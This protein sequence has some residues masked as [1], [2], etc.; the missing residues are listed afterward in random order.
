[1][2]AVIIVPAEDNSQKQAYGDGSANGGAGNT[3]NNE[4]DESDNAVN[5]G[6]G[7]LGAHMVHQITFRAHGGK[8]GGIAQGG[9]VVAK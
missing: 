6:I 2:L 8:D 5:G 7:Q 3:G 1:M 9:A 4:A